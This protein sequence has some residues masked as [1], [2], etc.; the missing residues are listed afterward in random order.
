[1]E[2]PAGAPPLSA[3]E[4]RQQRYSAHRVE[5]RKL[6]VGAATAV[7]QGDLLTARLKLSRA[8]SVL[9]VMEALNGRRRLAK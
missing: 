1:M 8:L 9:S 5:L 7:G 3:R 4:L 6:L 2:G